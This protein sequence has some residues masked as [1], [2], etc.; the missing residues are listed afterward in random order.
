MNSQKRSKPSNELTEVEAAF[1]TLEVVVCTASILAF[2]Q[3]GQRL[4]VD[5]D[6]SNVRIGGVLSQVQDREEQV[7]AYNSNSLNKTERNYCVTWRETLAIV[8]TLEHFHKCLY[9][10]EIQ[11]CA[12]LSSLNWLVSVKNHEG[13]TAHWI[14][15]L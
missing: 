8:R 3:P 9:G 10:Q 2:P 14:Q 6:W 11:L 12:D 15:C 4:I 1:Q 5:T 13:Q 7:I